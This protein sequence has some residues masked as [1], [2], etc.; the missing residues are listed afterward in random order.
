M[1]LVSLWLVWPLVV[2]IP[3]VSAPGL[4]NIEE[5]S[6]EETIAFLYTERVLKYELCILHL[7]Y[8]GLDY[9]PLAASV[10]VPSTLE[11]LKVTLWCCDVLKFP[12]VIHE[13][14]E[15]I[16][17]RLKLQEIIP[18]RPVSLFIFPCR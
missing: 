6:R 13:M 8:P 15:H 1:T 11:N 17:Q 7:I 18:C 5:G 3:L 12:V 2:Y 9:P 14:M 16:T 4:G 10:K